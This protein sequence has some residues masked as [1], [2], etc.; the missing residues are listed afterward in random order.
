MFLRVFA[1]ARPARPMAERD[2][3]R[4]AAPCHGSA[5]ARARWVASAVARAAIAAVDRDPL[6]GL[7]DLLRPRTASPIDQLATNADYGATRLV[8]AYRSQRV[9]DRGGQRP[10]EIEW[11]LE[12]RMAAASIEA[13]LAERYRRF[14]RTENSGEKP[15][16]S[17][18][19]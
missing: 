11:L 12:D 19:R 9:V 5:R 13:A 2:A 8:I 15:G 16:I 4:A 6:D 1:M 10:R 18:N 3:V 17:P 7:A 14:L